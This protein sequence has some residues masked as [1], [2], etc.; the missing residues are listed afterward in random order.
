MPIQKTSS[1]NAE[2]YEKD[3]T[4]GRRRYQKIIEQDD[5]S[6]FLEHIKKVGVFAE[7]GKRFLELPHIV[8]SIGKSS[9]EKALAI[10]DALAFAHSGKIYGE[11]SYEEFD[12]KIVLTFPFFEFVDDTIETL[13]FLAETARSIY[14]EITPFDDIR[15]TARFDYFEDIGEKDIII[16]DVLSDHPEIIDDILASAEREKDAILNDPQFATL[17]NNEAEKLGITPKEYLDAFETMVKENPEKI[18]NMLH[19]H[20][21]SKQDIKKQISKMNENHLN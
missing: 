7:I 11:V 17:I 21:I 2:I 10:L 6:N 19:E 4:A 18:Y 5:S 13:K 20:F 12:A 1:Q 16:E 9:Y 3:Y 8:S 15:M 14:F